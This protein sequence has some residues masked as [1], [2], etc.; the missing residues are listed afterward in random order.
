[1]TSS[2]AF[3]SN[4]WFKQNDALGDPM[5]LIAIS[6]TSKW[7][8]KIFFSIFALK[9]WINESFDLLGLVPWFLNSC[10]LIRPISNLLSWWPQVT[11]NNLVN[12]KCFQFLS[13]FVGDLTWPHN[14]LSNRSA[15]CFRRLTP[16]PGYPRLGT[17]QNRHHACPQCPPKIWAN[18]HLALGALEWPRYFCSRKP[19][20]I[21]SAQTCFMLH[22]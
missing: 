15:S 7:P 1:M 10:D 14:L 8:Q 18:Q 20:S 9:F 11:S 12:F 22:N 16:F 2:F 3:V 17:P 4:F 5:L 13:Q 21:Q 19:I 6:V